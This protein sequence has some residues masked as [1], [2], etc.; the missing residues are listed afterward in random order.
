MG[1]K[2]NHGKSPVDSLSIYKLTI[3]FRDLKPIL[4]FYVTSEKTKITLLPIY[5]YQ[6]K[7]ILKHI[8]VG[9]PEKIRNSRM[10]DC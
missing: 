3:T 4:G 6:L 5:P 7:A 10:R 9:L 8:S 1:S 2:E